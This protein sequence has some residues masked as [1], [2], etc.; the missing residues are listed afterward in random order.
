MLTLTPALQVCLAPVPAPF[1]RFAAEWVDE[2]LG[3]SAGAND[4]YYDREL[5]RSRLRCILVISLR[6]AV[7]DSFRSTFT[8]PLVLRKTPECG[9]CQTTTGEYSSRERLD[10]LE[11]T[12]AR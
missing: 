12:A 4:T 8:D 10:S 7:L 11:M 6:I 3:K 2:A 5:T 1:I 9:Q